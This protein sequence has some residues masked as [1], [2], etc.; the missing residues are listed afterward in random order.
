MFVDF[1]FLNTTV[2]SIYIYRLIGWL[3]Y[4]YVL[5]TFFFLSLVRC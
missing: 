5:L 1:S 4:F 2:K 3:I